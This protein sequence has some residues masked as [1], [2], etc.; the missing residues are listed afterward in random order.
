[1][2]FIIIATNAK[3][4]LLERVLTPSAQMTRWQGTSGAKG[5]RRQ[6]PPT[7]LGDDESAFERAA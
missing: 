2:E 7:A 1:M 3:T 4:T 5:F 6:A